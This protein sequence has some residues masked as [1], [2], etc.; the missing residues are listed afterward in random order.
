MK[1]IEPLYINPK[2]YGADA[3]IKINEIIAF[4]NTLKYIPEEE[5]QIEL[6]K[7]CNCMTKHKNGTCLKCSAP[8]TQNT[9]EEEFAVVCDN[10]MLSGGR[11][12]EMKSF[13]SSLLTQTRTEEREKMCTF[14]GL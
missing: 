6:C 3:K 13:I 11:K 10:I 7:K 1:K 5:V 2:S 8:E 9:W 12:I 4:L 14:L